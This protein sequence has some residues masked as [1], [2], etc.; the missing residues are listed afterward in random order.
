MGE[1]EEQEMEE[2]EREI[3]CQRL[4]DFVNGL[5]GVAAQPGRVSKGKRGHSGQARCSA[6]TTTEC[7]SRT[8]QPRSRLF[9]PSLPQSARGGTNFRY[10][11]I[12][13]KALDPWF[14]GRFQSEGCFIVTRSRSR[15]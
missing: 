8:T 15:F 13:V 4:R 10:F 12:A 2:Q 3:I 1:M 14:M 7:R 9:T 11:R 5:C 6:L